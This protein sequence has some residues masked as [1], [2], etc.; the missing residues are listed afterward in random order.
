MTEI[1]LIA[2]LSGLV[3]I[4][5]YYAVSRTMATSTEDVAPEDV[6]ARS[7][8]TVAAVAPANRP[9]RSRKPRKPKTATSPV[10]KNTNKPADKPAVKGDAKPT[11]RR[12]PAKK[13]VQS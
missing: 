4:I 7:I 2:A 3:L 11:R 13:P 6:P 9:R 1:I 8:D 5:G 10:E 12:R